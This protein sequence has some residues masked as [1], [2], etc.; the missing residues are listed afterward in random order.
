MNPRASIVIPVYNGSN[1]LKEAI[2]S[3]LAQTYKNI[4]IVVVNDGSTDDGATERIAKSYGSRIRYFEKKNGG[5]ASALNLGIEMMTGEYFSWLSHDD[6]Y[7]KTKIEDQVDLL[8][9]LDLKDSI[10]ACNTKV[11]FE[12]GVRKKQKIDASTFRFIDIFL[13]TSANVGLNGCSLLIPK[14]AFEICGRFNPSLSVT[15][16][17]DLW[18]RM[19]D[20]YKFVLLDKYL[21]ISRRHDEQDSVKKQKYLFESADKLHASFLSTISYDR[22]KKYFEDNK[23]NIKHTY[24]NY[25]LYKSRGYS[26]TAPII[27]R[28]ILQYY[29]GTD[30]ENFYRVFASE[31]ESVGKS[32][33]L[34]A[35]KS[36]KLT[37]RDRPVI[38]QEYAVILNSDTINF[39]LKETAT[40]NNIQRK[41]SKIRKSIDRF[42]QSVRH[43]GV[44][45]T[46]EKIV[47]KYYSKVRKRDR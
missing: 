29:H 2:D 8:G 35:Q 11:L 24:G 5:V 16:D 44:Y 42:N 25:R 30:K 33:H 9:K 46:V 31:I 3:A 10:I 45:L 21:V 1:Y 15:Q 40:G 22:F 32:E 6:M 23:K 41:N 28:N 4:E 34:Q 47:R 13:S 43:D 37:V 38:D 17:Y 19:K 26:K 27:L 36:N 14:G 12:S 7:E 39:L 18:F 20:K